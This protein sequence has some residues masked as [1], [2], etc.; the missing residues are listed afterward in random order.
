MPIIPLVGHRDARE[1]LERAIVRRTLPASLLLQG[2]RGVGK[3]RLALWLA[4]R[5]V[6]DA[7]SGQPCD[8]CQGCRFVADLRH[9]DVHWFFPRPRLKDADDLDKVRTDYAEA[10]AERA[11]QEGL[12]ETPSGMESIFFDVVRVIV[13]TAAL[14]PAIAKRKVFIIGDAERMV[15]QEGTEQAANAFL[16][17]LE[18]PGADTTIILTSSEPGALLPTIRSR[19]STIRVG[20]LQESEVREFLALPQVGRYLAGVAGLPAPID[21]RAEFAAG[22]PGR[23]IS[24]SV[25]VAARE[26]AQRLLDAIGG[27]A[28]ATYEA[29]WNTA[30]TKARGSFADTLDAL[31][32]LLHLRARSAVARGAES[33]ATGASRAMEAVELAKERVV[34]NVSPQLITVNLLREL[35]ELLA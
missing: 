9:P 11:S 15:P 4:Q 3:Q 21:E 8:V 16:K 27:K 20:P 22:A 32:E 28:S 24:A 14:S 26:A 12:Y 33:A 2:P 1:R 6:C 13:K 7:T 17:L 5:L 35:K 34:N 30:S 23:L 19:V 10:I 18:E 29:A 31:S 25:L